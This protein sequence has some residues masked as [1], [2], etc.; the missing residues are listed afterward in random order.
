[1]LSGTKKVVNWKKKLFYIFESSILFFSV[2]RNVNYA[3]VGT[4]LGRE[5]IK[6]IALMGKLTPVYQSNCLK[7]SHVE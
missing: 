7:M 3:T 6:A 2:L 5:I 1:M 4:V